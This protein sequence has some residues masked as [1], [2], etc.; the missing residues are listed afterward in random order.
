MVLGNKLTLVFI[1]PTLLVLNYGVVGVHT[2]CNERV[3]FVITITYSKCFLL[4]PVTFFMTVPDTLSKI[5]LFYTK[6]RGRNKMID[7]NWG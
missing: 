1:S 7:L 2:E 6:I 4:I 3:F 5:S